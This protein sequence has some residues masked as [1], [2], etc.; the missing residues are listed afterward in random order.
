MRRGK[1]EGREEI[2]QGEKTEE[3]MGRQEREEMKEEEEIQY[4]KVREE[5]V[6]K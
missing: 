6:K 1:E 5:R 4:V 2:K 3:M